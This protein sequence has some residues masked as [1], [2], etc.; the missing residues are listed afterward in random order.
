MHVQ[1]IA[2]DRGA[3]RRG[4]ADTAVAAVLML[5]GLGTYA[6]WTMSLIGGAFSNGLLHYQDGNYPVLHLAAEL[7]MG[8]AAVVAAVGLWRGHKWATSLALLAFGALT[9]SS[10]NS[11]GW[12]IVNQPVLLAPMALT[13]A[14]ACVCI[15]YLLVRGRDR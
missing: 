6:I 12:P 3:F 14:A 11:A 5:L 4:R 15:P 13:L 9:Y 7:L 8:T 1:L 10:I 2:P